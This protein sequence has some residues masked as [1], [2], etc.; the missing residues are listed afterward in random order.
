MDCL[1]QQEKVL[2]KI[3]MIKK[4]IKELIE[5]NNIEGY[6]NQKRFL[7]KIEYIKDNNYYYNLKIERGLNNPQTIFNVRFMNN[8]NINN[9]IKNLIEELI[10]IPEFKYTAYKVIENDNKKYNLILE[11]DIVL[12]VDLKDK[13]IN[14]ITEDIENK[15]KNKQIIFLPK[16]NLNINI[17]KDEIQRNKTLKTFNI[18]TTIFEILENYNSLENYDNKK[19]YKLKISNYYCKEKECYIYNFGIIRGNNIEENILNLRT[20]IKD[21]DILYKLIYDLI[22][23]YINKDTFEYDF[24]KNSSYNDSYSI[25]LKNNITIQFDFGNERD[26]FFY[27]ELYLNNKKEKNNIKKL[28]KQ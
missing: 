7:I 18:F 26:R 4:L 27:N 24:I 10:K 3:E 11:N 13:E 19:P 2:I 1:L 8:N 17:N 23:Q 6:N 25:H 15:F 9:Y 12:E 14:K 16:I 5:Y 22:N 28:I 21:N 20:S